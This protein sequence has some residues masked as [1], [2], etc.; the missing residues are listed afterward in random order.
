MSF[1]RAALILAGLAGLGTW[2]LYPAY[3]TTV[4][5]RGYW[6]YSR[7][8]RRG[9]LREREPFAPGK[10]T[11]GGWPWQPPL[12]SL[13]LTPFPKLELAFARGLLV[14]L[15]IALL[16]LALAGELGFALLALYPSLTLYSR[17]LMP[18]P[19][20]A[21]LFLLSYYLWRKK[22]FA[23]GLALGLLAPLRYQAVPAVLVLSTW[24][25]FRGKKRFAAGAAFGL[26]ALGLWLAVAYG[27]LPPVSGPYRLE[28]AP[29]NLGFLLMSLSLI[30]PM[31]FLGFKKLELPW[32]LAAGAYALACLP[33]GILDWAG[34][35]PGDL[36]SGVRLYLPVIPLALVG[37]ARLFG[38][39]P[40]TTL[41]V[42]LG[43]AGSWAVA[44]K[45]QARLLVYREIDRVLREYVRGPAFG[46][47][48]ALRF[49]G[50]KLKF[51]PDEAQFGVYV[52][53][54]REDKGF[55]TLIR[56]MP[57][58][59]IYDEPPVLIKLLGSGPLPRSANE[60]VA[61]PGAL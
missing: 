56:K 38:L 8:L 35:F 49:L 33:M 40:L 2:A 19:L 18:E 10:F 7:S 59:T 26:A 50:S 24:E 16:G 48:E 5:D 22:P 27:G 44:I 13:T 15:G 17:T 51:S 37:Y 57:G 21:L 55:E 34:G 46:N 4:D 58:E 32:A 45:H 20:A 12:N 52:G 6:E 23:A 47:R 60:D 30:Y 25:F 43:L 29:R 9:E 36:V 3:L 61:K 14:H 42:L 53:Y 54:P 1:K 41:G 39:N 31:S 11:F 28:L